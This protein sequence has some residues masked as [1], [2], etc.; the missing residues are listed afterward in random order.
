LP[1]PPPTI[2]RKPVNGGWREREREEPA[3]ERDRERGVVLSVS[4]RERIIEGN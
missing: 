3:R 4:G 2:H 1:P